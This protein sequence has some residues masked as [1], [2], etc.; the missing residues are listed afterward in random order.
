MAENETTDDVVVFFDG[1]E[2]WRSEDLVP[3]A[4]LDYLGSSEKLY[5]ADEATGIGLEVDVRGADRNQF[6]A[7]GRIGLTVE[8]VIDDKPLLSSPELSLMAIR[9]ERGGLLVVGSGSRESFFSPDTEGAEAAPEPLQP[10][11]SLTFDVA[12]TG[13]ASDGGLLVSWIVDPK[14]RA[15]GTH[16]WS[17]GAYPTVCVNTVGSIRAGGTRISYPNCA[18]IYATSF[19]VTTGNTVVD[20]EVTGKNLYFNGSRYP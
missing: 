9:L 18:K 5:L 3:A 19:G 6:L 1:S 11:A 14:I 15:G 4:S 7:R 13:V 2:C 10:D 12:V 16:W 8:R 20:Y 17:A